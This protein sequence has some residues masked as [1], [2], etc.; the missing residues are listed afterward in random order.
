MNKTL[1][2]LI[3]SSLMVIFTIV[4]ITTGPIIMHVFNGHY[5]GNSNC[6]ELSDRYDFYKDLYK[7]DDSHKITLDHMKQNVN[8][9]KRQKAFYKLE[10][11]VLI[12]DIILGFICALLALF[13]FFESGKFFEK[14]TGLIGLISGVIIFVLTLVYLIY[15]GIIFTKDHDSDQKVLFDNGAYK[16]WDSA[17]NKYIYPYTNEDLEKDQ[18]A[19]YAKFKDLGKKQYNYDSKLYKSILKGESKYNSCKED[20]STPIADGSCEYVWKDIP[21]DVSDKYLYDTWVTSIIFSA[22]VLLCSIIL[23][24]FGLLIFMNP[25][26]SG[27]TKL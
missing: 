9:C 14:Y 11:A 19:R 1:F 18:Y 6:Q 3:A 7:N 22:L 20:Y 13:H 26:S 27:H 5:D 15:S 12:I 16:K 4:T 2:F 21:S 24:V 23:A 10:Y 8:I 25:D 17:N